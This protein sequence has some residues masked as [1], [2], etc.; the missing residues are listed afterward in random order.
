MWRRIYRAKQRSYANHRGSKSEIWS[1]P[2][3]VDQHYR[4]QAVPGQEFGHRTTQ[5]NV[6]DPIKRRSR[7][8]PSLHRKACGV[9]SRTNLHFR[10]TKSKEP[11]LLVFLI[12][13]ISGETDQPT[14][15]RYE[16]H[17]VLP[18]VD[19]DRLSPSGASFCQEH[20]HSATHHLHADTA[21]S[22]QIHKRSGKCPLGPFP[23]LFP[24]L[25]IRW[26]QVPLVH[27]TCALSWEK[28]KKQEKEKKKNQKSS[29]N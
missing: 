20:G 22:P 23:R 11:F 15:I 8:V 16:I 3:L 4:S 25:N 29:K 14:A 24:F 1:L 2:L 21:E 6:P 19:A 10:S 17:P 13:G 26:I 18:L 28:N 7:F 12:K 27:S 5:L 9:Y